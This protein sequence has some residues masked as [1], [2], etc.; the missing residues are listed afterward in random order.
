MKI[1]NRSLNP[2]PNYA[3]LG[4]SGLDIRANETVTVMPLERVLVSTGLFLE[5]PAEYEGQLRPRSGLSIKHGITL[6][7]AVGTIDSDYRDELKVPIINLGSI[8]Y[9][10]NI[11]DKIAQLVIA[12]YERVELDEVDSLNK[13]D[14]KGGFNST[15]Y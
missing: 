6:V 5:I 13:T 11:G 15:G 7:N 10:I 4:S 2:L 14:R 3:T 1:V 12:K 9:T 8:P